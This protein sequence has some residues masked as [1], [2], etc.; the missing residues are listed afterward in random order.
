MKKAKLWYGAALSALLSI[1]AL[2]ACGGGD[3]GADKY[4]KK[5]RLILNVRNVYFETW[6]GED[7]YTE[8]LNEMFGVKIK[9][10]NCSYSSW[11]N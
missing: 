8:I 3:N 2:T 1:S 5:G 4:D 7:N 10:T 9:A 6:Q 11:D